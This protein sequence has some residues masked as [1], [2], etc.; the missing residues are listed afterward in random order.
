MMQEEIGFLAENCLH[1]KH[2]ASQC[3]RCEDLCPTSALDILGSVLR[4]DRLK[5]VGCGACV[6]H[7]PTEVFALLESLDETIHKAIATHAMEEEII[8]TCKKV[9]TLHS[10][11]VLPCLARLNA[12]LLLACSHTNIRHIKLVHASC[13]QCHAPKYLM[14]MLLK[15]ITFAQK[16]TPHLHIVPMFHTE[17]MA[18]EEK[19]I[20]G[21]THSGHLKRRMFLAL[22]GKKSS[23]KAY[24]VQTTSTQK[25]TS[26][27]IKRSPFK[28]HAHFIAQLKQLHAYDDKLIWGEKPHIN[29]VTCKACSICTHV[30]PTGALTLEREEPFEIL[31]HPHACIECHLCE[32]V[33]FAKAI[34]FTTKTMDELQISSVSLLKRE[35][36]RGESRVVIYRT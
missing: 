34:S 27:H 20:G 24:D 17:K 22:L 2:R 7:C 23:E 4:F 19:K 18:F 6:A 1:S 15:S 9:P 5:C 3:R 13:E 25:P 36:K 11:I 32:D 26:S 33:C 21:I 28:K 16:L 8:F 35:E 10:A 30:C 29:L 31:F 12:S 14:Q